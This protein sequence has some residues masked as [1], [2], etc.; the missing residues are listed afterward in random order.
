MITGG[1]TT[2]TAFSGG[3]VPGSS[4]LTVIAPTINSYPYPGT[5]AKALNRTDCAGATCTYAEE[6]TNYANWYAYYRTRMQMMKTAS[7]IAFSTVDDKFRVG[8]YSIN[9]SSGS[10][11]LNPAAFD[12]VQK[13][14]WY[15]KFLGA[16]PFG[17]TPLRNGLANTG[18]LYAGKLSSLNGVTANDPMQY[19]CQQNFTILSTD[20]YWNDT[21][22]PTKID[23]TT[24]IGQQDNNDLRPYYDG[25]TQ[26]RTLSQTLFSEQQLGL[27]TFLV[28][29]RTQ[30]Q[31]TSTSRLRQSVVTTDTY[32][33]TLQTTQLQTRTTPLTKRTYN[34]ISTSYPLIDTTQQLQKNDQPS[35]S[36]QR[37]R[38]RVAPTS[39][40]RRRHPCRTSSSTSRRATNP[41]RTSSS[42]SRP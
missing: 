17:P 37:S 10:Q 15:S 8:Y 25:A 24:D 21:A 41:C 39:S 30:Q 35:F 14:L 16:T 19:S 22:N 28:E 9:N 36:G 27:N 33:F 23:G 32:P 2:P 6:M 11:F 34:L 26:T 3:D 31:Q 13:N 5:A 1:T 18:R 12:G 4:L 7:S 40:R 38:W 42:T 29:Q 20:G